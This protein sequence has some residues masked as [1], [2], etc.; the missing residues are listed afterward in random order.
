M[1]EKIRCVGGRGLL[2]AMACMARKIMRLYQLP[3]LVVFVT[4]SNFEF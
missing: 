3:G 4:L 1:K 2:R